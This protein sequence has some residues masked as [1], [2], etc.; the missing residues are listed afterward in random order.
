M[1]ALAL[2]LPLIALV[3]PACSSEQIYSSSQAYRRSECNKL[4]DS[5]ERGRCMKQADMPYETYKQDT[6]GGK[7]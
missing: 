4:A 7:K 3:L 2:C 5:Q 1:K 6:E